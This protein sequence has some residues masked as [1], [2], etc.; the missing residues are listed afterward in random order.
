MNI[1]DKLAS[2]AIVIADLNTRLSM[3]QDEAEMQ[4]HRAD[5]AEKRLEELIAKSVIEDE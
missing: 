4:K 2:L 1:I 5:T 3:V